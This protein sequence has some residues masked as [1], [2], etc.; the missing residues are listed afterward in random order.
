MCGIVGIIN[1]NN[2]P[3]SED[4]LLGMRDTLS[5]R[6]PDDA[7][8]YIST[9]KKAGLAHRR[10][11]IIDLSE[12]AHQPMCNEDGAIWITYNGEIYNYQEIGD[13]L[14]LLGHSF[15]SNSDTEVIIHGYEE[16]GIEGLL[17]KLRGMF[18]FAIYD[19][20]PDSNTSRS[21]PY[22][23]SSKLLIARDRLG[24]KPSVGYKAKKDMPK[25]LL[26]KALNNKLPDEI[27][28]R[29]KMG[30]TF[31]FDLW[32][33]KELKGFI[34]ERLSGSSVFNS[35]FIKGLLSDYYGNRVHWSRVWGCVV[36]TYWLN[37]TKHSG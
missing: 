20:R 24:I 25:R 11:S 36:L 2:T 26:I 28:H 13:R 7:G 21:M 35:H 10:L 6:G 37:E 33:R 23:P 30:F 1:F 9:D 16:W 19:S 31:P 14:K 32:M 15:K 18:A 8:M 22:A 34:E 29:P 5:H 17:E 12:A 3:I 27:V 4:I